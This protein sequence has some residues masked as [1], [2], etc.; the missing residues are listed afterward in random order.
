MTPNIKEPLE[1]LSAKM[2]LSPEPDEKGLEE[3]FKEIV[4]QKGCEVGGD[5]PGGSGGPYW[6]S[7]QPGDLRSDEDFGKRRGAEKA[8]PDGE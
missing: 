5:C 1:M 4:T 7:R 8:F 3:I 2:N 6:Q